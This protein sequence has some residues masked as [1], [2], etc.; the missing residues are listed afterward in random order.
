MRISVTVAL[1]LAVV[2]EIVAGLDGLGSGLII[3]EVQ[4]H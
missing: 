1:I 4:S 3:S 2:C